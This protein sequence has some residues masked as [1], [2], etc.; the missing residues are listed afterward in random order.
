MLT[1]AGAMAAEEYGETEAPDCGEIETE[2][3]FESSTP[4]STIKIACVFLI[5]YFI[6]VLLCKHVK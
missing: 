5:K 2:A 4:V 1:A 6:L 3:S